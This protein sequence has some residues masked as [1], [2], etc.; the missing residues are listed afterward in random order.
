MNGEYF[1]EK[2]IRLQPSVSWLKDSETGDELTFAFIKGGVGIYTCQNASQRLLPGSIL[3]L[4]GHT[5]GKLSADTKSDCVFVTFS[6]L[7]EHVFPLFATHEIGLLHGFM[8]TFKT[9]KV[10]APNTAVSVDCQPFFE[11]AESQSPLIQR[12]RLLRVVA[13]VLAEE[14]KH[15]RNQQRGQ[16]WSE[17]RM[18]HVL[19]KLPSAELLNLSV[20]E[21]AAKFNCSRRHLNRLFHQHFNLSITALRME[22]RLLKAISLLRDPQAKVINVAEQCGFNHLGLFNT[23]FKRRFGNSPGQWRKSALDHGST[24]PGRLDGQSI[25]PLQANR[26][27]PWSGQP[28]AGK[29]GAKT[30]KHADAERAGGFP[31]QD[32][33]EEISEIPPA[34]SPVT[35]PGAR[36]RSPA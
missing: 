31:I 16:D 14:F 28:E 3:F 26:L 35:E 13:N 11:N 24:P 6:L 15:I 30:K 23:C 4:G 36:I 12:S 34:A 21:L 5:G 20:D 29:P 18:I 22:I 25:C 9:A 8:D 10:Y 2:L 32:G 17:D 33:V 1:K 7:F 19:E 27:C